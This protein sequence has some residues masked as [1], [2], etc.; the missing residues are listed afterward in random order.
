MGK[1]TFNRIKKALAILLVVLFIATLTGASVSEQKTV[2][3]SIQNY[4]YNPATVQISAGDTVR[5]TNMDSVDH[6]VTGSS[7]DSGMIHTGQSYEF[8]FTTPG[9][10]NYHCTPHPYMKGTVTV[11]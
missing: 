6:T 4:A 5:W 8:H 2:N 10:Y 3:V 1:Q 11:M 7:F 9:V